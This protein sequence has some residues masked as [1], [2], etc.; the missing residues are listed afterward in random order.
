LVEA[1][2]IGLASF[3]IWKLIATDLITEPARDWVLVRSPKYVDD[4]VSC[5]W[6]L[7]SWIAFGVTWLT[8][9]TIGLQAPVLVALASAVVVGAV[10]MWLDSLNG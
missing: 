3:R 10:A 4:L 1:L 7:G 6:C 2:L 5:P 8:D 9:A